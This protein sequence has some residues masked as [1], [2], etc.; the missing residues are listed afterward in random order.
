[1]AVTGSTF[2]ELVRNAN[3]HRYLNGLPFY[4]DQDQMIQDQLCDKLGSEYCEGYGLG[5]A[6]HAIAQ[7]IAKAIDKVIKTNI[8][9]CSA[10]AQRRAKLNS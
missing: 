4:D 3:R 6:V 10:C 5:D 1:M 7:P 8:R 9:G 2:D